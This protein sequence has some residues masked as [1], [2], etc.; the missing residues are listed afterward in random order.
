MK[1]KDTKR[2]KTTKCEKL[3]LFINIYIGIRFIWIKQYR[4]TV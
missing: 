2:N 1:S 3:N 4:Y